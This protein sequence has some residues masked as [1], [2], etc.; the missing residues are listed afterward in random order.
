[1]LERDF[2]EAAAIIRDAL[3]EARESTGGVVERVVALDQFGKKLSK[4]FGGAFKAVDDALISGNFSG[5]GGFAKTA[6]QAALNQSLLLK[7]L[8]EQAQIELDLNAIWEAGLL[9]EAEKQS[10]IEDQSKIQKITAGNQIELLKT[11]EKQKDAELKKTKK[12]L[13]ISL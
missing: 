13:K 4:T 9:T 6:E 3:D 7:D 12:L 11:L 10:L 1:M 2:P 8:N 5:D